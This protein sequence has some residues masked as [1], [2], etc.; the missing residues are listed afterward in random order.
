MF[1]SDFA[2]WATLKLLPIL[3][4]VMTEALLGT[5]AAVISRTGGHALIGHLA[6][7]LR[8]MMSFLQANP[9]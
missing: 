3:P 2:A 7:T 1:D 5:D 8:E 4:G 9:E 6:D